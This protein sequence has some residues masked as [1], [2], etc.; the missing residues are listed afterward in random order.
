[1]S[2]KLIAFGYYGGKF[3]HLSFILPLL[4]KCKHYCEPFGGSAAVLLNREPSPIETYNDIYGEVVNFFRCLRDEGEKLVQIL[5]LTPFSREELSWACEK[6]KEIPSLERARRFY[7]CSRQTMN[8]LATTASPGR[9]T[10]AK[11]HSRLGMALTVSRW[12]GGVE[13]LPEIVE[14][15]QRVQIENRPAIRVIE[16]YDT[17]DTLFYCDPPYLMESRTGGRGY[18]HEMTEEEHAS[19]AN[20]LH[21]IKGKAV[22]SGY[23]CAFMDKY[24]RDWKRVD[25]APKYS[26]ASGEDRTESA[27]LNFY[28]EPPAN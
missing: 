9:W 20:V 17:P 15:L 10:F 28:D 4:P 14:R 2:D 16:Q 3:S 12:L 23:N 21:S 13:K 8:G 7:V 19:L 26:S 1:M 6:E 24:F 22:L 18:A 25:A 11:K 5:S 27:W